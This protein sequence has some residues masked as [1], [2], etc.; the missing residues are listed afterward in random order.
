MLMDS[1]VHSSNGTAAE[2]E[3]SATAAVETEQTVEAQAA[4]K[5]E[6]EPVADHSTCTDFAPAV[7]TTIHE[8]V[9]SPMA[10]KIHS[11]NG[12]AAGSPETEVPATSVE[13]APEKEVKPTADRPAP[14]AETTVPKKEKCGWPVDCLF[15][16]IVLVPA[17]KAKSITGRN[18][19]LIKKMCEETKAHISVLEGP[20]WHPD[21]IVLISGKEEIEA[22]LSPA[23][24]AVIRVFKLINGFPEDES[25]AV[26]SIPF[27][28]IRLLL[29][30]MQAMSLIGNQGSSINTIKQNIG[31]SV[32]ILP[33][34]EVST[35]SANLDDR[36][37]NLKGEGLKVLQALEAVLKHLRMLL[38][39]H[40][41]PP[42]FIA[43]HNATSTLEK[44]Q[45]LNQVTQKIAI[46]TRKVVDIIGVG[47]MNIANI[48]LRSGAILT[49]QERKGL[50]KEIAVVIKG[51]H[52]QVKTAG[53]LLRIQVKTVKD[54]DRPAVLNKWNFHPQVGITAA[55]KTPVKVV[56][57][58][59]VPPELPQVQ[60]AS[61]Q[62]LP[63]GTERNKESK[64]NMV[65]WNVNIVKTFLDACI[66]E[67]TINGRENGSLKAVSW[68]KVGEMLKDGHKFSVD[69]IQMINYFYGLKRK[70]TAWV[71]LKNK[72]PNIYN[73]STNTFN[74]TD[75]EWETEIK[76]NKCIETL[77]KAP[78][79]F[80]DLCAQLFDGAI[81]TAFF[82]TGPSGAPQAAV[83]LIPPSS[84]SETSP[85]LAATEIPQ[86]EPMACSSL[87]KVPPELPQVQ[88]ASEPKA[89]E[90]PPELPHVQLASALESIETKA[91]GPV[92]PVSTGDSNVVEE[93]MEM[94]PLLLS[95]PPQVTATQSGVES[96]EEPK[97]IRVSW[98]NINVVK[99]FLDACI[100]EI[101]I[102][103]QENGSLKT[104]SWKKVGEILKDIHNFSI[105]HKQMKNYFDGLKSKYRA[106]LSLKNKT[107]NKYD[108]ST[109]TFHLTDNEWETEIKKN[110]CIEA[111]RN[112][113][114]PFPDLCA[115]LFG[116]TG[117]RSWGLGFA[118]HIPETNIQKDTMS[119]ASPSSSFKNK[120][121]DSQFSS[122]GLPCVGFYQG[123]STKC[124]TGPFVTQAKTI[125]DGDFS[126]LTTPSS[127]LLGFAFASSSIPSATIGFSAA[128]VFSGSGLFGSTS[129]SSSNSSATSLFG[130][131]Y[132][133]GS[134]SIFGASSTSPSI[135]NT[136]TGVSSPFSTSYFGSSSPATMNTA[137]KTLS[138]PAFGV[139]PS[140]IATTATP[141]FG[142]TSS[143]SIATTSSPFSVPSPTFGFSSSS[144]SRGASLFSST[145]TFGTSSIFG[146][147]IST[148]S[149][150]VSWPFS[151]GLFGSSSS[152]NPSFTAATTTNT[153]SKTLSFPAFGVTSSSITT[154]ATGSVPQFANPTTTTTTGTSSSFL[155]SK[156]VA[157][158]TPQSTAASSLCATGM[159][160]N[161][162]SKQN[163][164]YWN[165]KYI[166]WVSL[167]NK[168]GN[169]YD[170]STNM[171]N[172]TDK[173]WKTEL[174]KNKCI[175]TLRNAPLP[176]PDLCAQLFY[177]ALS[178][179]YFQTGVD[180]VLTGPA[181]HP[182]KRHCKVAGGPSGEA[183][184]E[185]QVPLVL[186][187][188]PPLPVTETPQKELI[189]EVP[190]ELPRVQPETASVTIETKRPM[191][192][193]EEEI[194]GVLK[195]IAEK[196]N[197]REPPP[198][199][200]FEDC[201]N[202]LNELGWPKDD[203]LHEVAYAIFCEENDKYRE[204]WMKLD[205]KRCANWV[206][207]I[208]R[209]KNFL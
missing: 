59:E 186:P 165:T 110:K 118:K 8:K 114:L 67:I 84:G 205:P 42:L 199:P 135:W 89:V 104:M 161:K 31:C 52:S 160:S 25:D 20:V 64:Q 15:R 75:K 190:P 121:K 102:N 193:F 204:L 148:T 11:A 202:K 134:S 19:D 95:P 53:Q 179:G 98:E 116:S 187:S 77:R 157:A 6:A 100:H 54:R 140:S 28:S 167:R 2:T 147:S 70:Y 38:V 177:G 3:L 34:D 189:F 141:A 41:I 62:L 103:G 82:Q 43:T 127:S 74:L 151:S 125:P 129:T 27:C 209:S 87:V 154:T 136:T 170:P 10:S 130:L 133:F 175:E 206:R 181:C 4:L 101:T 57:Q 112:A 192:V 180:Q 61:H 176:F 107:N 120:H 29:T 156:T 113:P 106:W 117:I 143:S 198:K 32:R 183:S 163:M 17:L 5:K 122:S 65:R 12:T 146:A 178:A 124:P 69:H 76:K 24:E 94:E 126:D 13:V 9:H 60:P 153:A 111:L 158:T 99:T 119:L 207:M 80:P 164:V 93:A 71:S 40:S 21:R 196:M 36:V 138:L 191:S 139:T 97:R 47:G 195:M 166:A 201:E 149:T 90:V 197:K 169:K 131:P 159:E 200:T 49:V 26:A 16:V 168:A 78:L 162:E 194:L 173:E 150:V 132:T 7:E 81:S 39:D 48:G 108:P 86:E 35:L 123:L 1:K 182:K 63:P 68:K 33:S 72:T 96:I 45:V 145:S 56:P 23:M 46:S 203:P 109:N 172:L 58:K 51:T 14:A 55:T 66:H 174:M 105:D 184:L 137:T 185:Q 83:P 79:R 50:H 22:P 208:G 18:G 73:P 85:L 30:S 155:G 144:T 92:V 188:A 152:P 142:V 37:V 88:P 115:Q 128:S 171:F 91:E 44:H